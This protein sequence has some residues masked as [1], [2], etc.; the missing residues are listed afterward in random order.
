ME[1]LRRAECNVI[2][3][4]SLMTLLCLFVMKAFGGVNV[5]KRLSKRDSTIKERSRQKFIVL[6]AVIISTVCRTVKFCYVFGLCYE[7]IQ[8]QVKLRSNLCICLRPHTTPSTSNPLSPGLTPT[9]RVMFPNH[10]NVV[11]WRHNN[12][13]VVQPKLPEV[14]W[15]PLASWQLPRNTTSGEV[16]HL[17]VN[18]TSIK[19]ERTMCITGSQ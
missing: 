17:F 10:L 1:Q 5:T 4:P 9:K 12:L 14:S 13:T 8:H 11:C 15:C 16:Y 18:T 7:E 2:R 6:C 3:S 19:V